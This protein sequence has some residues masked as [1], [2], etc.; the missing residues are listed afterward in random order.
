MFTSAFKR[1]FINC[2]LKFQMQYTF[3]NRTLK[4]ILARNITD[5]E[6]RN[7]KKLQHLNATKALNRMTETYLESENRWGPK[8][9]ISN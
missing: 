9:R 8:S 2:N 7:L 4:N 3:R 6:H 5:T 1:T